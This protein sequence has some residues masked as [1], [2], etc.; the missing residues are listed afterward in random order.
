M[1]RNV[2]RFEVQ[3]NDIS[4]IDSFRYLSSLI[5]FSHLVAIKLNIISKTRTFERNNH[6]DNSKCNINIENICS[7]IPRHVKQ[8]DV[9]VKNV[10]EMIKILTRLNHLCIIKFRFAKHFVGRP[11]EITV[12]LQNKKIDFTYHYEYSYLSIWLG[13][14]M[15]HR[16]PLTMSPPH[17]RAKILH[18]YNDF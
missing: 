17:K 8:L 1:F 6:V 9:K 2:N 15:T 12:W 3:I 13:K 16:Q 14:T 4:S 10:D 18:R 7:M 11:Q 5:D